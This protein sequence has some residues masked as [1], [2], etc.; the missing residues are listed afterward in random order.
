MA[1]ELPVLKIPTPSLR[2][3]SREV[4]LVEL[5][6][7]DMQ[8]F[9]DNM[10]PTMYGDDGIGLAAPQVGNNVRIAVIG[11]DADRSLETDL[12]LVNPMY[13]RIS[14]KTYIDVEGCLSVPGKMGKVKRFSD[15]QVKALDRHGNMI[16]FKAHKYFARV[17]QHEVDHLDGILYIDRAFDIEDTK[18]E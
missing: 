17:I 5:A 2:V 1:I 3:R 18:D 15:I 6:T 13:E 11:K 8:T 16:E 12:V 10:I 9:I 7:P 4:T 14:K